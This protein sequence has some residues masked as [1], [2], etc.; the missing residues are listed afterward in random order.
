MN[1]YLNILFEKSCDLVN[2]EAEPGEDPHAAARVA[3]RH[4]VE[5]DTRA[6][7]LPS[8]LIRNYHLYIHTKSKSMIFSRQ[9]RQDF[10]W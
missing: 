2:L 1:E 9:L 8:N 4:V 5:G 10:V 3:E 7:P 6:A